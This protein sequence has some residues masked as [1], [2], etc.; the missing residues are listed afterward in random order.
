MNDEGPITK[1]SRMYSSA[2]VSDDAL[3]RERGRTSASSEDRIKSL[4]DRIAELEYQVTTLKDL[5]LARHSYKLG[6]RLTW[7]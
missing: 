5:E 2:M 3:L 7:R 1:V 4:E 6:D